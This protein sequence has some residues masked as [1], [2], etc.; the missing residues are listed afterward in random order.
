MRLEN[1]SWLIEDELAGMAHP[2][3]TPRAFQRLT[4]AGIG[5]IVTLTERALPMRLIRDYGLKALHLPIQNFRPPTL[6]QVGTFVRFIDENLAAGRPVVAH[7]LAGMGRTGTMLACYLVKRG[8]A[9]EQAI[10]TVRIRRPGSIET[11]G[12]ENVVFEYEA[13]L[14][15]ERGRKSSQQ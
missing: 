3:V 11:V 14:E 2:G 9:A 1:F 15:A 8:M 5:A 6:E 10:R 13:A 12:Q 4:D 7:C